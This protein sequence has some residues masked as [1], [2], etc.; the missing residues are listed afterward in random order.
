MRQCRDCGD[1]I[2]EGHTCAACLEIEFKR[3]QEILKLRKQ[4]A[5]KYATIENLR[6]QVMLESKL[7]VALKGDFYTIKRENTR[8]RKALEDAWGRFKLIKD[9]RSIRSKVLEICDAATYKINAVLGE[10]DKEW[11]KRL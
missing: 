2:V 9:N 1:P 6:E 8:L 11:V 3:D 5:E 7:Y 10:G 4:L